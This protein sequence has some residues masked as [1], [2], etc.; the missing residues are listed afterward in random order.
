MSFLI[1][2]YFW[3]PVPLNGWL[4]FIEKFRIELKEKAGVRVSYMRK[5]ST[6]NMGE[7]VQFPFRPT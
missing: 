3:A 6:F 4:K 1:S 7:P 5:K 2:P